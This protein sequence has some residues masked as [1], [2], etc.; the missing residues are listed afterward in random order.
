[1]KT[2]SK[3]Q[4]FAI[5][6]FLKKNTLFFD[7]HGPDLKGVQSFY[8]NIFGELLLAESKITYKTVGLDKKKSETNCR[9]SSTE[10]NRRK[11]EPKT[12][13]QILT[14]LAVATFNIPLQ[15]NSDD[16]FVQTMLKT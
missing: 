8:H 3:N 4:V 2:I 14:N 11:S 6:V 16:A 1:M 13:G 7:V 12:S 9:L 10:P 15:A 5:F